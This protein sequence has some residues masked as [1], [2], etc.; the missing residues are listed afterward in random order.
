MAPRKPGEK[1]SF[2]SVGQVK[3]YRLVLAFLITALICLMIFG[4]Y[5]AIADHVYPGIFFMSALVAFQF[6][7]IYRGAKPV[8]FDHEFLY[9]TEPGYEVIVP[10]ENIKYVEIKNIG[11]IYK[12][13]F[14]DEIQAGRMIFFKP[15]LIYPLD[16]L[17]Q[18]RKVNVLR[19]NVANARRRRHDPLRKNALMS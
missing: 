14:F 2:L 1:I 3:A 5:H 18:D 6:Y 16:F 12:V 13:A 19:S 9:V 17:R 10:L 7:R 11:G 4:I 15:S 8:E